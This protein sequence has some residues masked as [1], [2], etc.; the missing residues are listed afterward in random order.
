MLSIENFDT[1]A[2]SK[3]KTSK[4]EDSEKVILTESDSS[5]YNSHK[6][7]VNSQNKSVLH[8]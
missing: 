5:L 3:S 8:A 4:R 1:R 2:Q 7:N 6:A